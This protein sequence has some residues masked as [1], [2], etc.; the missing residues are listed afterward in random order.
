MPR[1]ILVIGAGKSTSHLL[2]YFLGKAETED[3]HLT[4]GDLNPDAIGDAIKNHP[5]C[6]V[7]SMDIFKD[8]ERK[9]AIQDSDIVV[10][11]LPASLHGKVAQDCLAF[12]KHLV[13]ASYV[14]E[15]LKSLDGL[16]KEK[17]LVFMNEMGLD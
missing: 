6:S 15:E 2:D 4:I 9:K 10:S 14:S 8:A 7:V 1:K 3:L 12:E 11:M 17:G 16:V 5:H 13:T